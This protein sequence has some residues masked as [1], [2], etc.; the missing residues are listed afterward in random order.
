MGPCS[1]SLPEAAILYRLGGLAIDETLA[2]LFTAGLS[3]DLKLI[4]LTPAIAA[5]TYDLSRGGNA[6]AAAQGIARRAA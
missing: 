6:G 3:A 2:D 1:V 4:E 5:K